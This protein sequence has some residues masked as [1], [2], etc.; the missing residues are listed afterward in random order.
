MT[1]P[2]DGPHRHDPPEGAIL[3][4]IADF[5]VTDETVSLKTSGLGSCIGVAIHDE[6][7]GVSGLLH[8]MLPSATAANSRHHPM[9][10]FADSGLSSMLS[11]FRNL[12]GEP[13]RAWAKSAGAATMVDFDGGDRTIGE[14]NVDALCREL[15]D[16]GV[17]LAATDFGG[18]YGRSIEFDPETASLIVKRADG[19]ERVL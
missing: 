3:V 11:A 19:V 2:A 1:D 15:E 10:K 17:T 14:R 5:A 4:G 7:A 18:Q 12:G 16:N 13:S 8:F 9:A 6:F